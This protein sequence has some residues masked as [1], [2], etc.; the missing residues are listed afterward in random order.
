MSPPGDQ[1]SDAFQDPIGKKTWAIKVDLQES[2]DDFHER[3]PYMAHSVSIIL[4]NCLHI[5]LSFLVAI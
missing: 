2:V 5:S 4:S 3:I 1:N